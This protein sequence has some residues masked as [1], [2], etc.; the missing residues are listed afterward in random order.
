M[1]KNAF[2]LI[3]LLVV[4]AII[5]ILAAILFPVFATAREKARQTTCAS[6]MKQIGTAMMQY[7]QDY[8]E[9]YPQQYW[10]TQWVPNNGSYWLS[11]MYP[12]IK[13]AGA[14]MCPD[15]QQLNWAYTLNY[16]STPPG[17]STCY[18]LNW[19]ISDRNVGGVHTPI[20]LSRI[21]SPSTIFALAEGP[22]LQ[23]GVT[24]SA[25]PYSGCYQL[26][27]DN[28][29]EVYQNQSLCPDNTTS[30]CARISFP[31]SNGSNYLYC[32]GHVKW[33]SQSIAGANNVGAANMWGR[34]ALSNLG[35]GGL[36]EYNM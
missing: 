8:D 34:T 18:V 33:V 28:W 29:T 4:I 10:T 2:T 36:D 7:V 35:V 21:T 27:N 13:S 16:G 3:E 1:R 20:M 12:Y 32:D 24:G 6:N 19:Y 15:L 22:G 5:A 30:N 25:I 11:C 23:G 17:V 14:F 9:T 31:H 26:T